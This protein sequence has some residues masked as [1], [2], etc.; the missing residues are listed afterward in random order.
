VRLHL[1]V[2]YSY[3]GASYLAA[4]ASPS[5]PSTLAGQTSVTPACSLAVAVR[6]GLLQIRRLP[7]GTSYILTLTRHSPCMLLILAAI[8]WRPP[9]LLPVSLILACSVLC[10]SFSSAVTPGFLLSACAFSFKWT[11]NLLSVRDGLC[12]PLTQD[13]GLALQTDAAPPHEGRGR[14]KTAA[15]A[16]ASRGRR[17]RLDLTPTTFP[18]YADMENTGL[19]NRANAPSSSPP[20]QRLALP[21]RDTGMAPTPLTRNAH[22]ATLPSTSR[23]AAAACWRAG[24]A[25]TPL[26][27]FL[28]AARLPLDLCY[29]K[30]LAHQPPLKA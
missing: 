18:H 6:A 16:Q 7:H 3:K 1:L 20:P 11:C 2:H 14:A 13:A 28:Y 15:L 5:P 12:R 4:D 8:S 27:L 19:S 29:T 9:P 26:P 21:G 30:Q 23:D 17:C 10:L 22:S 24:G 25:K